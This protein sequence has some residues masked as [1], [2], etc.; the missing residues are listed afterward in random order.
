V[1]PWPAVVVNAAASENR[2]AV[3]GDLDPWPLIVA[4]GTT[5]KETDASLGDQRS[6]N[7]APMHQRSTDDRIGIISYR[8][9]WC[10][11][12]RRA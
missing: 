1:N 12:R 10:R 7:T 6:T 5:L 4:H 11:S 2:A 9:R 3:T 8:R